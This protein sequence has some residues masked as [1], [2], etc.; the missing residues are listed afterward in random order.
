V[1]K[2]PWLYANPV[3]LI[4]STGKHSASFYQASTAEF[5]PVGAYL[6]LLFTTPF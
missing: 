4:Y 5:M 1:H 6:V 3:Y 2:L